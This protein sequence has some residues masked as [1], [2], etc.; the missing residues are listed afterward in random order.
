MSNYRQSIFLATPRT[1]T[2]TS[3]PSTTTHR[4]SDEWS[5]SCTFEEDGEP[6]L[7]DMEQMTSPTDDFD[8]TLQVRILM[9]PDNIHK[10][11]IL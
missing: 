3:T 7:C 4:E 2:T 5:W 11:E 6:T 10:L 8:W 9:I 1:T